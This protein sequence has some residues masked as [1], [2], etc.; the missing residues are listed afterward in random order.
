MI[1]A[2][3]LLVRAIQSNYD[4]SF[5]LLL[6]FLYITNNSSF[7]TRLLLFHSLLCLKSACTFIFIKFGMQKKSI[8]LFTLLIIIV[9]NS[10]LRQ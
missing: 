1:C 3:N 4:V 10:Y 6:L 7:L 5:S 2:Q 9:A 8:S